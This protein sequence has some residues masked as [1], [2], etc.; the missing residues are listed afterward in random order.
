MHVDER[1]ADNLAVGV[2]GREAVVRLANPVIVMITREDQQEG[3]E[4]RGGLRKHT[5]VHRVGRQCAGGRHGDAG[6][7]DA[8]VIINKY[9][10]FFLI[11]AVLDSIA[12][13]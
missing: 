5:P 3:E 13:S 7:L 8:P 4:V 10:V 1:N 6:V 11:W 9:V 2:R 12:H